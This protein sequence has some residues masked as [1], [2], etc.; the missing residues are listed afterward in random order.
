MIYFDDLQVSNRRLVGTYVVSKDE[1]IEFASRWEPQPYH[2][3]ARAAEASPY[4]GLTICSLHLFAICTRL[5]L[6][7]D[8]PVAVTGML[9]KDEVRFPRAARPGEELRYYTECIEKRLSRSRAGAG[10]VSLRDTLSNASG[11]TVLT[12]KVTLMVATRPA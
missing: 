8:D 3:D 6:Q 9:G 5:F 2:V 1:A 11:E 12:Q 10:I 4:G 7:Q